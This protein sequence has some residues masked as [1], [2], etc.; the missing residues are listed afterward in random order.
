[1]ALWQYLG[2][3]QF[4]FESFQNYQSEFMVMAVLLVATIWLREKGSSE[5]KPVHMNH[6]EEIPA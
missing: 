5:S 1:M 4:W 3:S 6:R 2:T